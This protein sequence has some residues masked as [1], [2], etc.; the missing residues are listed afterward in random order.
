MVKCCL[1]R[2]PHKP[3]GG[4]DQN[5]AEPI[6]VGFAEFRNVGRHGALVS[7][8]HSRWIWRKYSSIGEVRVGWASAIGWSG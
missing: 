4:G 8:W 3:I 6:R 2:R 7:L 1:S 5:D